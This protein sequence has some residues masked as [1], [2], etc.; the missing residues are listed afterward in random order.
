MTGLYK[1]SLR[2]YGAG[3]LAF[4]TGLMLLMIPEHWTAGWVVAVA[5]TAAALLFE[6][7]WLAGN[8]LKSRFL[9]HP[10]GKGLGAR[11][12]TKW[13]DGPPPLDSVAL[14]AVLDPDRRTAAGL[15]PLDE[16]PPRGG[17]LMLAAAVVFLGTLRLARGRER[18][19]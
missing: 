11:H 8:A 19:N 16:S 9:P 18:V 1:R 4:L 10:V 7:W 3:L 15:R 17:G 5:V 14:A 13:P 6:G 2:A 12:E